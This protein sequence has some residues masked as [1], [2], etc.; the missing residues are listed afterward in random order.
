MEAD[1]PIDYPSATGTYNRGQSAHAHGDYPG[2]EFSGTQNNGGTHGSATLSLGPFT[3]TVDTE[4]VMVEGNEAVYGGTITSRVGPPPPPG[5]PM[6]IGDYVY[7]KVFDNGQGSN[8]DPDQFYGSIKFRA[9]SKCGIYTP[10]NTDAWPPTI[11]CC[12]GITINLINDVPEPGSI[13]VNN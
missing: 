13:K 10:S 1:V 11:I 12:G 5:A 9:D 2:V 8:A 6:N 7:I 4:C 3:F